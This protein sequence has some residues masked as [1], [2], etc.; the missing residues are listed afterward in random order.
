[1]SDY[2]FGGDVS[3]PGLRLGPLKGSLELRSIRGGARLYRKITVTSKCIVANFLLPAISIPFKIFGD[4]FA[5]S[6]QN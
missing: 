1:M 4:Y 2:V 3:F 6:K 5:V